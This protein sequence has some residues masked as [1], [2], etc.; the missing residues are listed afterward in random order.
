MHEYTFIQGIVKAILERLA[1]EKTTAPVKEVVLKLG[2]LEIHSEAAAR[3][4][5]EVLTKGTPLEQARLT[6][7]V[8]PVM[9]QCPKC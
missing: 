9:L 1:E 3:Q 6:V 2:V 7:E 4:A 8:K 5:F